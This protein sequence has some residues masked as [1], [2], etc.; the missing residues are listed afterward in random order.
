[1]ESRPNVLEAAMATGVIRCPA[2]S[3]GEE[4][5]WNNAAP[6][7]KRFLK[8]SNGRVTL[9]LGSAISSFKPAQ[10]PMWDQ[11]IELLWTA[12]MR[13]GVKAL[14]NSEGDLGLNVLFGGY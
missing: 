10:L 14:R 7:I 5:D 8:Q 1:M 4:A 6:R 3:G 11:F 9:F 2:Q 12:L 13:N